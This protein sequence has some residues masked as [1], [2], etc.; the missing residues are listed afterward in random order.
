MEQ[1][2]KN[3]GQKK[4]YTVN[5]KDMTVILACG[6]WYSNCV[7]EDFHKC[8]TINADDGEQGGFCQW[9]TESE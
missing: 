4:G 7:I 5:D 6:D 9:R 1:C 8:K 3:F 2:I